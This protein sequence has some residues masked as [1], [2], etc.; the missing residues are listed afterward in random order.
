LDRLI[1][2]GW[3]VSGGIRAGDRVVAAGAGSVW[4]ADLAMHG[5]TIE[6]EE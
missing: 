2:N 1:E 3:L 4:A 6:E 5:G